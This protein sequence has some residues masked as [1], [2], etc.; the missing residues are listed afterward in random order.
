MIFRS[1]V[2]QILFFFLFMQFASTIAQG[3]KQLTLKELCN[4]SSDIIIGKIID[5][6]SYR[7]LDSKHVYTDVKI[8]MEEII[9]GKLRKEETIIMKVYGGNIDGKTVYVVGA[10][11]YNVG[12]SSLFFLAVILPPQTQQ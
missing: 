9:H 5:K 3:E 2:I 8:K 12:T 11:N 6:Q 1:F 4:F 7:S 10:P